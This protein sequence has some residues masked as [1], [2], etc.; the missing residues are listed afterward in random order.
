M[1]EKGN[2]R[3]NKKFTLIELLV[4]IAIIAIL[5]S[6]LLPALGQARERGTA[7]KCV[8][9]L[10]Q[11]GL[12][13]NSY[14]DMSDDVFLFGTNTYSKFW[15]GNVDYQWTAYFRLWIGGKANWDQWAQVVPLSTLCPK[16]P[17]YPNL[18]VE[19][20]YRYGSAWANPGFYGIVGSVDEYGEHKDMCLYTTLD[21]NTWAYHKFGRVYSPSSK[22]LQ[23]DANNPN[24]A[25][26]SNKGAWNLVPGRAD[27]L[28]SPGV[29]YCHN[30]TA[31][32]LY[33]DLHVKAQT[34]GVLN[35]EYRNGT[36]WKPYA[37]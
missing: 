30:N 18:F 27:P 8:S 19:T 16:V 2:E 25:A 10:K 31:S 14:L 13:M 36:N 3:M 26:N 37:K 9:N 29:S 4:V 12:V 17:S 7:T 11:L 34:V 28:A 21:G 35:G 24:A 20:D 6:M 32:V 1:K 23:M 33:F 22:V 5:A 15:S